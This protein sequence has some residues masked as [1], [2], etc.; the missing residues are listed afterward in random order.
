[1]FAFGTGACIVVSPDRAKTTYLSCHY[2]SEFQTQCIVEGKITNDGFVP[3][4]HLDVVGDS[5]VGFSI[6]SEAKRSSFNWFNTAAKRWD[7]EL[8]DGKITDVGHITVEDGSTWSVIS[9]TDRVQ[10]SKFYENW[11]YGNRKVHTF[12]REDVGAFDFCPVDIILSSYSMNDAYVL[13]NCPG[14]QRI[15]KFTIKNG[16]AFVSTSYPISKNAEVEK[17]DVC[18]SFGE[19]TLFNKVK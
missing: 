16:L 15:F 18:I 13:S 6:S 1:M 14:D 4:K 10:I 11:V 9:F 19:I 17:I 2:Q 7:Y 5:I 12:S 8:Y 3:E